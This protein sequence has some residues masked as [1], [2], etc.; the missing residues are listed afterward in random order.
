MQEEL[1]QCD[2]LLGRKTFEIW[3]SYWPQHGDFWPGIT[4]SEK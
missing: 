3:E 1:K 4:T 2:Y